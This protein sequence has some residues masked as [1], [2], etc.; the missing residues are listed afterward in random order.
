MMIIMIIGVVYDDNEDIKDVDVDDQE[1][2]G[3]KT[4]KLWQVC[5]TSSIWLL[6]LNNISITITPG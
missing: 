4:H 6:A 1:D 3:L 2:K 5:K